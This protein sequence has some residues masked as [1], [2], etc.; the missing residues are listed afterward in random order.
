MQ[1]LETLSDKAH[2]SKEFNDLRELILNDQQLLHMVKLVHE[3][4]DADYYTQYG[5]KDKPDREY[6]T[7][8]DEFSN[9]DDDS[10]DQ[11]I[12]KLEKLRRRIANTIDSSG[13]VRRDAVALR[14]IGDVSIES[15]ETVSMLMVEALKFRI[16][17]HMIKGKNDEYTKHLRLNYAKLA[18]KITSDLRSK[19]DVKDNL[20]ATLNVHSRTKNARN[21]YGLIS[22]TTD[23]KDLIGIYKLIDKKCKEISA[24]INGYLSKRQDIINNTKDQ[25]E[26]GDLTIDLE[27][28]ILNT[29]DR[30]AKHNDNKFDAYCKTMFNKIQAAVNINQ[31]EVISGEI[32]AKYDR[33]SDIM[34]SIE[35]SRDEATSEFDKEFCDKRIEHYDDIL[36]K[37][38]RLII[39]VNDRY[40]KLEV[41]VD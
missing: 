19:F 17:L 7:I 12:A 11:S 33:I 40:Q 32:D 38:D 2:S 27:I 21:V 22:N 25:D 9:I 5:G 39:N 16:E 36:F 18:T 20:E 23:N 34:H 1:L 4:T 3:L 26:V 10:F 13:G 24:E 6:K 41:N 37:L 29:Y 14:L 30:L 8:F 28:K 31:L 15:F 35:K